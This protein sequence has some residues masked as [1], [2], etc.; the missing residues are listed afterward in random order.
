MNY[1]SLLSSIAVLNGTDV[2][3]ETIRLPPRSVGEVDIRIDLA[4]VCGSDIHTI[5]GHRPA[6]A[7]LALGHEGVGRVV[8]ID[9]GTVD[10]QGAPI[11]VGDRVVFMMFNK[12]GECSR[13]TSGLEMKCNRLMKYGHESV[14]VPPFA[15]GTI[16]THVRLLGGVGIRK[17]PDELPDAAAVA[18]SCAVSTAAAALAAAG[19]PSFG[20]KA[21]VV[22]YG[23]VG[24]Y[25][26]SMLISAGCAVSVSDPL[27][28]RSELARE[29]GASEDAG[30]PY[31]I[32]IEASGSA[33]GVQA[34]FEAVDVGGR[35]IL[36]GSVSPGNTSITLDPASL[37]IRRVTVIG[38]HNYT[39]SDFNRAVDWLIEEGSTI[40]TSRV[41]SPRFTLDTID[42]ALQEAQ[43]GRYQRVIIDPTG[44]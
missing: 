7:R 22:G 30:G 28:A 14:D 24:M 29:M 19:S 9:Q 36:V 12:C 23:A 21:L 33:A 38:V 1:D 2:S 37:V 20:A 27:P 6:P 25:C 34:A 31:A 40:P 8:D 13:C 16:A 10:L 32:V 15:T 42:E 35:V 44:A 11:A 4:A 26:T 18:T 43:T 5:L 41:L 39:S 3:V 17:V